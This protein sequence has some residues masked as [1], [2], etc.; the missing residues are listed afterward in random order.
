MHSLFHGGRVD[1]ALGLTETESHL[2]QPCVPGTEAHI[3]PLQCVPEE[4]RD[5]DRKKL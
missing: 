5:C 4:I 2:C 1:G 3:P